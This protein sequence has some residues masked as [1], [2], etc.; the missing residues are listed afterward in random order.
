MKVALDFLRRWWLPVILVLAALPRLRLACVEHGVNQPDEIFQMLEPAHRW[1]YGYGIQSWEFQDGARSWLLPGLLA[2]LWKLL[3][4]LGLSNPLVIVPLLRAPFVASGVYAAFLASRLAAR[5]SDDAASMLACAL[6]AF[7]PLALI[8]DFRTTTEAASAPIVILALLAIVDGRLVRAGA[9]AALLVFLRPSN[10]LLFM[11]IVGGLVFEGRLRDVARLVLGAL[12]VAVGGGVL[13]WATWG[14]PFHHLVE[15]VRFN[16]VESGASIFGI[17][18]PATYGILTLVAALPLAISFPPAAFGLLWRIPK[19]R[20]PLAIVLL[21]V[22]A[23]SAFPH[24]EPRFLLPIL[25]LAGALTAAGLVALVG[26]WF[27]RQLPSPYARVSILAFAAAAIILYGTLRADSL[28]FGDLGEP[29]GEARDTVLFGRRDAVNHLLVLAGDQSDLCGMLILGLMPNELFSGG[30]TYLHRDVI[31][32]SPKSKSHW[33]LMSKAANYALAPDI[34]GP[35]GW[36]RVAER[37]GVVLLKRPGSCMALPEE[38][39]PKYSRPA[40]RTM[41]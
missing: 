14:S 18:S 33:L 11:C 17:D 41:N 36:N 4:L 5:L 39:R 1:V 19:G 21:Y 10:G 28:T 15:Y 23:H 32:T 40:A 26:P 31:L 3:A 16:W 38:Y 25:P 12:P 8:L 6:A 22:A 20:L 37:G 29:R 13:D 34:P 27:A 2:L 35:P 30:K 7:M 24:K 9:W